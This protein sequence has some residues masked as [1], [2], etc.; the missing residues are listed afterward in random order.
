MVLTPLGARTFCC[1]CKEILRGIALEKCLYKEIPALAAWLLTCIV[2]GIFPRFGQVITLSRCCALL[3]LLF[4]RPARYH[5]STTHHRHSQIG[6][7]C[8]QPPNF[9]RETAILRSGNL[10]Q[11]NVL[12]QLFFFIL[13]STKGK[14]AA[15]GPPDKATRSAATP[16]QLYLVPLLLSLLLLLLLPHA[17]PFCLIIMMLILLLATRLPFFLRLHGGRATETA[18]RSRR[19]FS[20]S[21]L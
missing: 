10:S 5:P 17:A 4:C 6:S 15:R 16:E 3:L 21:Q 13:D 9:W 14:A 18:S 7:L 20:V 19:D 2:L 12:A 11:P 8:L 1:S